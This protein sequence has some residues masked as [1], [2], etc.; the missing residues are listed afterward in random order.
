MAILAF[1]TD[2]VRQ[3]AFENYTMAVGKVAYAWNYL[4]EKLARL[5]VAVIMAEHTPQ[6][7]LALWYSFDSDR[8]QRTLLEAAIDSASYVRWE[9]RPK[10]REDL[11]WLMKKTNILANHRNDAVHAPCSLVVWEDGTEI[12]ASLFSQH[13]KAKSLSGKTLLV[14]FDYVERFAETL[15]LFTINATQALHVSNVPWPDRPTMPGRRPKKDL[16]VQRP[17]I[18]P[19]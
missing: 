4:H 3:R 5:F 10:A 6:T 12:M 2:E 11:I 15:S 14:E 17:L 18:P 9:G 7:G 8:L 19:K 13:S 16:P 1:P